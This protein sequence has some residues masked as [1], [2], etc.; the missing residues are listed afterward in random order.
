MIKKILAVIS[1]AVC[2]G[3]IAEFIPEAAPAV[4]AGVSAAA[5][6]HGTSVSDRAK[7]AVLD[8]ARIAERRKAVCA[9]AWPYYEPTCLH[10]DQRSDG[11]VR[12]VRVIVADGSVTERTSQTRR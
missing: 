1:A 10:D 2:A 9:Q 12:V 7:P 11:T 5:Q 6:S 4:A 3:A 8:A